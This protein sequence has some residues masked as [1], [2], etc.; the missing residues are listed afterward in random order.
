[1]L[2]LMTPHHD[3]HY[4]P[5]DEVFTPSSSGD[6]PA[7]PWS[8]DVRR[9]VHNRYRNSIRTLDRIMQ[10]LLDRQCVVIITGDHGESFL[11]DGVAIHG[12]K[13]SDVQ[14][15]TPLILHVPGEG[16]A[17]LAGP[18]SHADILPTILDVLDVGVNHPGVFAGSSLLDTDARRLP[19]AIRL[20]N[21]NSHALYGSYTARH[22]QRHLLQIDMHLES[23]QFAVRSALNATGD[24]VPFDEQ[25]LDALKTDLEAWLDRLSQGKSGA[26]PDDPIPALREALADEDMWVRHRAVGLCRELG[27]DAVPLL[28]ALEHR[29]T[30]DEAA[31]VRREAAEVV[32]QLKKYL[33]SRPAGAPRSSAQ[34]ANVE[35]T[36]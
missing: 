19:I 35:A 11:D 9:R 26:I 31:E 30:A 4:A 17:Q 28:T 24:P 18:T 7:P 36:P 15:R 2:Y 3:Y 6:L 22:P 25:S 33:A 10:P 29:T 23:A 20:Y 14:M 1:M 32:L 5:E 34:P 13:L 27:P 21:S 16:A 8:D 12:T